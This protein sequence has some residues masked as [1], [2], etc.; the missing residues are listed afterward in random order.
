MIF[1][2]IKQSPIQFAPASNSAACFVKRTGKVSILG[3][4]MDIIIF[5]YS[6]LFGVAVGVL[7]SI[8]LSILKNRRFN[9]IVTL[10]VLLLIYIV[11]E[12]VMGNGGGVMTALMFGLAISNSNKIFS[13]LGAKKE[14]GLPGDPF[15]YIGLI[16]TL[17]RQ[18]FFAGVAIF[19]IIQAL[20]YVLLA[21]LNGVL[22]LD[23]EE[24]LLSRVVYTSGL[25][26]F[27]MSQMPMIMDPEGVH[28]INPE[29]YP[30]LAMTVVI[31]TVLFATIVGPSIVKRQIKIIR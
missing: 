29:V 9:N 6:T 16:V 20:R 26:A 12:S 25:P 22:S 11:A 1:D 14:L 19:I 27:I 24:L 17:S 30:N 15:V 23:R 2:R 10:A 5:F 21:S 3:N 13:S 18:Y 7:L 8:A 4:F 31:G 28:F